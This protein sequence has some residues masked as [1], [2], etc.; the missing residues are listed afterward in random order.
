MIIFP[1]ELDGDFYLDIF[2]NT[3]D[4]EALREGSMVSQK[5]SGLLEKK[6]KIYIG[7]F[8]PSARAYNEK[9]WDSE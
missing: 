7:I 8:N 3:Q 9:I 5:I 6:Q 4:I 2:L 1:E